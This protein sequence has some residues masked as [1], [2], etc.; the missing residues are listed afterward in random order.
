MLAFGW[1]AAANGLSIQNALNFFFE[2]DVSAVHIF[3]CELTGIFIMYN[4]LIIS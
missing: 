1:I 4:E 3:L 2:R